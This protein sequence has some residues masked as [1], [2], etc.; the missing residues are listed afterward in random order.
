VVKGRRASKARKQGTPMRNGEQ[1]I[2]LR[3]DVT[4]VDAGV[5]WLTLV[6]PKASADHELTLNAWYDQYQQLRRRTGIVEDAAMMG[7]QGIR[8]EGMFVG[9]RWDGAMCRISGKT[10]RELFL[11]VPPGDSNITRLD[12]QVTCHA[13]G[14]GIHPP[15]LAAV[16]AEAANEGLPSSRRRNVEEHKDNKG[17]YTTY[18]GSRQSAAFARVYHKSAQDPDA[19]GPECYRYEVQFNKDSAA[20]VLKALYTHQEQLEHASIAIVWDWF[21]R[22]GVIPVFKRS[23]EVVTIDR[24]VIPLTDLDKKLA[25]LYTQV[26]PTVTA[27]VEQGQA[28]EVLCALLGRSIGCDIMRTLDRLTFGVPDGVEVPQQVRQSPTEKEQ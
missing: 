18:I 20:Q 9:T 6:S 2:G 25:W 13:P 26:R 12:V 5:D 23:G 17:G 21:E 16:Q 14:D 19:Y 10:A 1:V 4:I 8:T 24:E 3:P 7:Y 11:I 28:E 22:R 15:R 27:L